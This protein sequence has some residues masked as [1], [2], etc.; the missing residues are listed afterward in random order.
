[1][2][3]WLLFVTTSASLTL[4]TP[5]VQRLAEL[6]AVE[7]EEAVV[8]E[9]TP[10]A[11]PTLRHE[12][13]K[14]M[15]PALLGLTIEPVASLVD[16]AFVSRLCGK[17]ALT[18]V[19]V[20]SSIFNVL[21]KTCNFL[22]SAT[23][24]HVARAASKRLPA[25]EIDKDMAR[26]ASAALYVA[27]AAGSGITGILRF[28]GDAAVRSLGVSGDVAEAARDYLGARSWAAPA[29][30]ALMALQGAFRGARDASSP[31]VALAVA[32]G[33][34]VVLDGLLVPVSGARGAALATTVSQY[35]GVALLIGVLSRRTRSSRP[36]SFA[37]LAR[38][39][40]ADCAL[41]ARSGSV[42]AFRTLSGVFAMQYASVI[43][44]KL[45]TANGAA[46]AI[47]YQVWLT[48]SLLADA[49]AVAV[50]TLLADALGN[51]DA[52]RSRQ[53]LSTAFYFTAATAIANGLLLGL[54]QNALLGFFTNDP[55]ILSAAAT[56][57]PIVVRS[58]FYCCAAFVADG[59]L[60]AACDFSYCAVAMISSSALSLIVQLGLAPR[61]GL[62][63]VWHGLELLMALRFLTGAGRVVSATGP[64][65]NAF[66]PPDRHK[67][68]DKQEADLAS[69]RREEDD[70]PF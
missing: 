46:H 48:A 1:M 3:L 68:D 18:G 58:Q 42:L 8:V 44:A 50:Q 59:C 45:G 20:A 33:A 54:G 11:T 64:W 25:G 56:I 65:A 57:W 37:G 32:T 16:T 49:V 27:L 52:P 2:L 21:S 4:P 70:T 22:Q 39:K 35:A 55:A 6:S 47:A 13:V 60:F 19:G 23:T 24:S 29:A 51:A 67:V 28:S 66:F 53:I 30:L 34:N 10:L 5:Q 61:L 69:S 17:S 62:K 31:V 38:P 9:V 40:P 12:F 41:V 26:V 7:L 36:K 43:A 15:A 14:I 63:G